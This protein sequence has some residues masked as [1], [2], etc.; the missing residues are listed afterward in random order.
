MKKIA[1]QLLL[2]FSIFGTTG[3]SNDSDLKQVD[4]GYDYLRQ[5]YAACIELS[6]I[7]RNGTY[8]Q[9]VEFPDGKY[10]DYTLY[11]YR[12]KYENNK[13]VLYKD[14]N[15]IGELDIEDSSKLY[16]TQAGS[17]VKQLLYD[18]NI[19]D[20]MSDGYYLRQPYSYGLE[21]VMQEFKDF[22]LPSYYIPGTY[23]LEGLWQ[24]DK[25]GGIT[26]SNIGSTAGVLAPIMSKKDNTI[27]EL[28][29]FS[30]YAYTAVGE[31]DISNSQESYEDYGLYCNLKS[32]VSKY[33]P[34]NFWEIPAEILKP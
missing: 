30:F 23:Q 20:A 14:E 28:L 18:F 12:I 29:R 8:W 3:C 2:I 21:P 22:Q 13:L 24:Y 34:E 31:T 16:F 11:L 32:P 19:T 17:S 1:F 7:Y 9:E 5:Q 26:I 27:V 10:N 4:D 25:Y 6:N 15:A 33:L